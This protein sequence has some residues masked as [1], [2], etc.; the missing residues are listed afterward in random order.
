[1]IENEVLSAIS[2]K[3]I[4]DA[5]LRN[6]VAQLIPKNSIA[7]VT[8]VGFGKL[9]F[10]PFE[11][12]TS[13]DF[14]SLTNLNVDGKFGCYLIYRLLQKE[15]NLTQGTSIKGV[16]KNDLLNKEL[17]VSKWREQEQIGAYLSNLDRLITLHQRK[18]DKLVNI[19]KAMLEKM[20]LQ[21]GAKVPQIRFKG[22]TDDWE[23]RKLGDC[24]KEFRSGDN[25]QSEKILKEGIYPVFGGNG[26]RGF[27]EK[28]NHDGEYALIGRQG[29]LCGNMNYS[30]GKA[31]FTEHA[32][33]VSGNDDYLTRYLFYALGLMNLGQYSG[34]S[35]QPGL[36]VNKLIELKTSFPKRTE[37]V[38]IA[39]ILTSLD[40]L[41]TL[42]QREQFLLRKG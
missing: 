8:R 7:I 6:S 26:R 18:H 1:M 27:A 31:Y 32:I 10:M 3:K 23:Q 5:G 16:T 42:H 25:I 38:K 37:Q 28:Y 20:F 4:T 9:S 40:R 15:K 17:L 21:D 2:K 35:A 29:A 22:F 11:Y 36:A 12:A 13:Q 34:Q 24:C 19:K 14:L 39:E 30:Q 33:A 41:I